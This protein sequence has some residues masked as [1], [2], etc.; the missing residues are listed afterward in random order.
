MQGSKSGACSSNTQGAKANCLAHNRR[1]GNVPSYVNPDL[2]HLNRTVFEDDVISGRKSI[3][4]LVKRAEKEYTEKTGQKCQKSFT[5]YRESCLVVRADTTDEQLLAFKQKA[6][7]LLGWKC[8]GIWVHQDEG[9]AKSKYVEGDEGFAINHHAHVLWDCIDHASG[10]SI[11]PTR[12]AFS[13]MQ[14]LL[15]ESTGMERGNYAKDTGRRHRTAAS[16]RIQAE[17]QRIERLEKV[18]EQKRQD[19]KANLVDGIASLIGRGRKQTI[20]AQTAEISR[21]TALLAQKDESLAQKDK[22][23]AEAKRKALR[24]LNEQKTS[25]TSEF[26]KKVAEL[27]ARLA[28]ARKA[29]ES[30]KAATA[31]AEYRGRHYADK[32]IQGLREDVA[33]LIRWLAPGNQEISD[34]YQ[35]DR[36]RRIFVSPMEIQWIRQHKSQEPEAPGIVEEPKE[37]RQPDQEQNQNQDQRR[38]WHR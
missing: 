21:L 13:K 33:E 1:E 38:G 22:D 29:V 27:N 35:T 31:A 12:N 7:Q 23:A 5:P 32:I 28:E 4:P 26:G 2:T 10:K 3:V 9:H 11:R 8:I 34:H 18:A 36:S 20:E 6:E 19:T 16:Q 17:E 15:A 25:L 24:A 37:E 30:A 14:D